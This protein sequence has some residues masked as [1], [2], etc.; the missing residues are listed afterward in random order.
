MSGGQILPRRAPQRRDRRARR[1]R[2]DDAR[3]RDALAVRLVPREPGRGRARARLDGPRTREG[4]HDP[5]QEHGGAAR[6]DEDQHR[7]H[8]RP[9]RLRRRGRARTDDGRRRPPARGRLGRAASPDEIRAAQGARAEAPDRARGQQGRPAGRAAVGGRRR[10]LRALPRPRRERIADRVPDRL[11]QCT[12]RTRRSRPGRTR[13]GPDAA[14]RHAPRGDP[15]AEP[16][17]RASTASPRHEPRREPVHGP[18]RTAPDPPRN[19]PQGCADCLVPRR[20]HD[21]ERSGDG[22]LRH[23]GA[24]ARPGRRG[25]P[26]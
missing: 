3:R 19:A 5:R 20:R 17:S 4:H 15:A 26:R 9:R 7:R 2:E 21:R 24:R 6:E 23:R 1:P 22:A 12:R 8:A 13:A 14:V 25:R 11:R 16:R 18:S 10:G